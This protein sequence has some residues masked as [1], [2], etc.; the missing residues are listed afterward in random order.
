MMENFS[1]ENQGTN[2]YLKFVFPKNAT[3]DRLALGMISNNNID[4]FLASIYGCADGISFIKY[5]ISAKV[6]VK[7]FLQVQLIKRRL[8]VF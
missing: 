5:N 2:T 8:L 4:G 7:Q 6:S 3:P 1:Y